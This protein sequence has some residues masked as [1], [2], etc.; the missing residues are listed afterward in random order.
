MDG[1]VSVCVCVM[2]FCFDSWVSYSWCFVRGDYAV[3]W[4][5][6]IRFPL[7]PP[8]ELCNSV[9]ACEMR[10]LRTPQIL[11]CLVY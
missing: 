11:S 1:Y 2:C 3:R 5:A 4:G 6:Y 8:L 7:P 10:Q 9:R